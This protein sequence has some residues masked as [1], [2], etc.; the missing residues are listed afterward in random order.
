MQQGSDVLTSYVLEIAHEAGLPIPPQTDAAMTKGLASFVDGSI[1]RYGPV[2]A[3]D[4]SLRKIAAIDALSRVGKATPAM[5]GS[6]TIDPNLWP[7]ITVVQW[8]DLL[9]R[10]PDVPDSANRK[11]QAEQ[12]IRSRI[13][14]QGTGAHLSGDPMWWLMSDSE[15]ATAQLVLL[16]IDHRLWTNDVSLLVR[17]ALQMQAHGSWST[18]LANAWGTLAVEA[19]A[20][21]FE[22]VPPA[23]TT[24][25]SLD[26]VSMK[27][28]WSRDSKGGNLNFAWPPK[29]AAL[30]IEHNG[31]GHPWAQISTR[32]AIPLNAPLF[33][34]YRITRTLAPVEGAHAGAW[35]S[36]DLVRV[37]L[38]IEASTDMTWVVV[39]DPIPAGASQLGTGLMRESTIA[40][41]GE[42]NSQN[43]PN[44]LSPTSTE[45]SFD[46][47]RAYYEFV[48]KGTFQ[49][50]YTMR[51]N[52]PGK[53][54]LPATRVE[55]LYEPEMFGELPNAPFE[56]AP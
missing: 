39:N 5:L 23:G 17:G 16:L 21:A 9:V 29:P 1:V 50:E 19:F 7:D 55:A 14:W 26:K 12:I 46:A 4:L 52:Q 30:R 28:D 47:F 2:P 34:G 6:I 33:N 20:R 18:T 49:I 56:V 48:P 36:G 8:W 44:F 10:L 37:H 35:R 24:D 53:F 13:N 32:A 40:L 42:N 11:T 41:A 3:A 54:L 31:A 43:T 45:R 22:P 15:S 25:A 38:T 51:L 27:L